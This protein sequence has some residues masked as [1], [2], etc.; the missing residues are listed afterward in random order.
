MRPIVWN[1][2][3]ARSRTVVTRDPATGLVLIQR[4]QDVD[5]ILAQNARDAAEYVPGRAARLPGGFRHVARIPLVVWGQLRELGIV[6]G[7]RVVDEQRFLRFL[8]ERDVRKLRTDN[9][10]RLA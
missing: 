5:A 1:N 2:A 3:P 9:G 4:K 8:S 10:R 6:K 7:Y